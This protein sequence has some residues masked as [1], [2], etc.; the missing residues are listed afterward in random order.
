MLFHASK[1]LK[2]RRGQPM[3]E[4]KAGEK[5]KTAEKT[6]LPLDWAD[7]QLR[8]LTHGDVAMLALDSTLHGD[9]D[10]MRKNPAEWVKS[11]LLREDIS[12]PISEALTSG[13]GWVEIDVAQR[14][15]LKDRLA[16]LVV[17]HG[18]RTVGPVLEALANPPKER[19]RKAGKGKANGKNAGDAASPAEASA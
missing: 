9:E 14:N 12:R 8:D 11:V 7:D 13:D 4:A 18:L 15:L 17:L 1:T 16:K 2:D 5:R 6:G 10:D 3:R 19:P